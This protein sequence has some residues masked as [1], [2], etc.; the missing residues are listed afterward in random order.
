MIN[1]DSGIY[2]DRGQMNKGSNE[3]HGFEDKHDG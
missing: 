2:K 1:K 3:K